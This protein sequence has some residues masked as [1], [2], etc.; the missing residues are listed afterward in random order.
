MVN[1]CCVSGCKNESYPG[2]RFSFHK[3]PKNENLKL[4]WGNAVPGKISKSSVICSEHFK[5]DDFIP[6]YIR[7]MLKPDAVPSIFP[8]VSSSFELLMIRIRT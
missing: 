1:S 5:R 7:K 4:K 2:S 8:K 6:G 3:F